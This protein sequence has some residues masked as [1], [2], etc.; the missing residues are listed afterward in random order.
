M[1]RHMGQGIWEVASGRRHLG[2]GIWEEA[3]GRRYL[4]RRIWENLGRTLGGLWGGS[5]KALG[6]SLEALA[7]LE[8]PGVSGM[9]YLHKV[10]PCCSRLQKFFFLFILRCVI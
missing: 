3:S 4:G 7:A 6:W 8:A 1:R 2:E 10:A 9:D 5:G